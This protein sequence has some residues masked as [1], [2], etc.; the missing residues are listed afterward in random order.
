MKRA[1]LA[2]ALLPQLA[3]AQPPS[4]A[5][6]RSIPEWAAPAFESAAFAKQYAPTTRL[7]PFLVQGDFSGD[8]RLDVAVLVARRGD[9]AEGIAIL[10]AGA[11]EPIVV[12][13]GRALGNGGDD[14]AWMDAWSVVPKDAG[15]R[16]AP[17]RG[18]ALLVEKLEAASALVYWDGAAYRWR[19][20]GD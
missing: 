17:R 18:D 20:Q 16:S 5:Q 3:A 11:R 1:A 4:P 10:H 6:A 7:N 9:G 13:A 2:L 19:Q 14:F 8:G 12:G 15:D